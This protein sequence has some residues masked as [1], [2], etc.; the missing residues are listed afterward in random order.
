MIFFM[1]LDACAVIGNSSEMV[2]LFEAVF[3]GFFWRKNTALCFLPQGVE[4][5][6]SERRA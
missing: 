1:G 2:E 4:S 3:G 6:L 5:R